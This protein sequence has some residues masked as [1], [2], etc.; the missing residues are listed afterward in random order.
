MVP[1][2]L[3]QRKFICDFLAKNKWV[4]KNASDDQ[5]H[6]LEGESGYNLINQ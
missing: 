1:Q 4:E 5:I 6:F 3:L 2:V